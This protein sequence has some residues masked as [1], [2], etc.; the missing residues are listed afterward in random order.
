MPAFASVMVSCSAVASLCST[1]PTKAPAA[2]R[3]IRPSPVGS[4]AIALT[5]V[6]AVAAADVGVDE[7]PERCGVEQRDVAGQHHDGPVEVGGQCFDRHLDRAAGTGDV[8]LVDDDRVG[9]ALD[10][11]GRDEV[12]LVPH[13]DGDVLGARATTAV[14]RTCA[15]SGSPASRCSTLGVDDFM[16]VPCP[17]ARTTTAMRWSVMS[18]SWPTAA[19]AARPDHGPVG[20]RAQNRSLWTDVRRASRPRRRPAVDQAR[21]P[22]GSRLTNAIS[23]S[24]ATSTTTTPRIPNR[25]DPPMVTATPNSAGARNDAARPVVA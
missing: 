15:M 22:C 21:A 5:K 7:E 24:P 2:S 1:T 18:P 19:R 6:A 10:D 17:A 12:T 8:V 13:D 14:R 16:R 3:T 4:G 20:N 23:T 25:V 11:L 9:R